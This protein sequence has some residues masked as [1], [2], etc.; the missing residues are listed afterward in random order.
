MDTCIAKVVELLP[1]EIDKK[2]QDVRNETERKGAAVRAASILHSLAKALGY[3]EMRPGLGLGCSV[4]I[5]KFWKE[6]LVGRGYERRCWEKNLEGSGKTLDLISRKRNGLVGFR[7]LGGDEEGGGGKTQS[8]VKGLEEVPEPIAL[9]RFEEEPEAVPKLVA[10]VRFEAEQEAVP[11]TV[12][13]TGFEE[14]LEGRI[15]Y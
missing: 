12:I 1:Q 13:L 7:G 11:E 14:L 5:W 6:E 4:W 15:F 3:G 2:L 9:A 8:K 10:L